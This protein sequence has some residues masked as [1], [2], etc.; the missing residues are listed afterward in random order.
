MGSIS[1]HIMPLAVYSLGTDTHTH[2][3]SLVNQT[4]WL[5]GIY[6]LKIISAR[7]ERVWLVAYTFFAL[8]N[9]RIL[10]IF[11]WCQNDFR[12]VKRSLLSTLTEGFFTHLWSHFDT[13]KSD[14]IH[15]FFRTKRHRHL[16]DSFGAGTCNLQSINALRPKGLVQETNTRAR[17]YTCIQTFADRSNSKNQ[18]H[19]GHTWFNKNCSY[20][21]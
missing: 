14:K 1:F 8:K 15:W 4:L 6:W 12:D 21:Y 3:H 10:S 17:K 13:N 19:A 16:P 18:A 20:V 9:Q 2:T 5:Q 7:S 11:N